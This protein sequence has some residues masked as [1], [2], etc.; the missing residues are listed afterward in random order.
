M[1]NKKVTIRMLKY[2]DQETMDR[3]KTRDFIDCDGEE[4]YG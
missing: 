2:M 3:L 1:S 4:S